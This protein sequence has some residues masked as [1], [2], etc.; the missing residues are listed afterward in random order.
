M[1]KHTIRS[2]SRSL[3]GKIIIAI[4]ILIVLGGGISWYTLINTEKRH[5]F[6]DAVSYA[7][8][9]SDLVKRGV[10]H[11][12]LNFQ[13]ESIQRTLERIGARED[14]KGI[15]IFNSKGRVFYSSS[16]EEIGYVVDKG[17]AACAG[18]HAG[19]GNPSIA[20]TNKNQW[21]IY[22]GADGYRVLTFIDPIYN[23]PSCYTAACHTHSRDQKVLGILETDFSLLPV[24]RHI[25]KQTLD[26]SLYAFVFIGLSSA[27]LYFV[28][29]KLVIKPVST[30]SAA[31]ERVASG[32]LSQ[33]VEAGSNDEMGL[34][35]NSF[36]IMIRE[37]QSAREKMENWTQTLE[38]R[39]A[40]KTEELRKSQDKLIQ[41]EKLA[42]LGRLTSDVAHE[43]RNPLTALGGF[44]RRLDR[45][46][47]GAKEKEYTEVL[48]N[49]VNR[50]EKILRNVLAFSKDA[51]FHLEQYDL[52]EIIDEGVRTFKDLCVER[53]INIEVKKHEKLPPVLIY[54]DQVKQALGN[55]F[56]NAMDAM[57]DGGTLKVTPGCENLHDV[58]YVTLKVSDTGK[59]IPEDKLP[60]IFEPFYSTKEIGQGTGLGLSITKKI[61]DAHGG[62]IRA[63]SV[64]G[65]GSTFSLYF[66]SQKGTEQSL[67]KCWEYMKCGR[68][69][70][71]EIKCPAYPYFGRVCWVV[72]GTFCEGKVQ[73]SFAQ[74]YENCTKCEFYQKIR[75]N[76]V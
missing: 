47:T 8:S 39:V 19:T 72:A 66:P 69:K 13:R 2:I 55:I 3:A 73:G 51:R 50:L 74:K 49:E 58:T 67:T 60:L 36:N 32:D 29:R 20:L 6:N 45:I 34:L 4:G 42:A 28:L 57:P 30:L 59:G 75:A 7:T 1:I 16:R 21:T 25:E 10:R 61:M 17:A 64:P 56:S 18:C 52:E 26:I 62:F 65:K 11:S 33:T 48:I 38:E 68:D 41:A 31:M 71:S 22:A 70:D 14:I 23:E 53:R 15:K 5:L 24:D 40:K 76:K 9:Y 12:M 54:R 43:I 27:I 37:L 46:V 63:E 35:T 44:V